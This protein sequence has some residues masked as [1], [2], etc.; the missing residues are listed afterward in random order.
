MKLTLFFEDTEAKV[1][2][3]KPNVIVL[4]MSLNFT[5]VGLIISF[6]GLRYAAL[7]AGC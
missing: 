3:L 6:A 5:R 7:I 2:G 4:Q 1:G